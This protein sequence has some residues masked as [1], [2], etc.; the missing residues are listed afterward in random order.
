MPL[1]HN[2]GSSDLQPKIGPENSS[3][4][5]ADQFLS[6]PWPQRLGAKLTRLSDQEVHLELPFQKRLTNH[7]GLV[8][9]GTIASML[10]DAGYLLAQHCL[11]GTNIS[12]LA[13]T[14]LDATEANLAQQNTERQN[15]EEA[16]TEDHCVQHDKA[17]SVETIDCQ[18][19]YLNAAKNTRLR[20]HATLLKQSKRLAFIEVSAL[21]DDNKLIC[22]CQCSFG[23]WESSAKNSHWQ[24]DKLKPLNFAPE[25]HPTK[26]FWDS[27]IHKPKKGMHLEQMG[28]GYCRIKVEPQ[29]R[30]LD[31]NGE[32]SHGTLLSIADN[33]GTLAS[34]SVLTMASNGSTI[35]LSMT[36]CDRI[37]NE[38]IIC[39]GEFTSQKGSQLNS[40]FFV[41]GAES[42]Q[43]KAFG[44]TTLWIKI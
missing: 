14:Q 39:F 4:A 32:I 12:T 22:K 31:I 7:A 25:S 42:H 26:P 28:E 36:F 8:H 15:V 29:P 35:D 30:F 27:M 1:T 3:E 20:F 11:H 10:H 6:T 16:G 40:H 41:V 9:G 44:T 24:R 21:D 17:P 5:F 23:T 43:L 33:V 2:T 19:F 38:S 18:I 37:A 34:T 13:S